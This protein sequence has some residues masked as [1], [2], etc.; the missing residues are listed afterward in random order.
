[1]NCLSCFWVRISVLLAGL[2]MFTAISSRAEAQALYY[3]G[4]LTNPQGEAVASQNPIFRVQIKS[5]DGTCLLYEETHN[6]IS[7]SIEGAFTIPLGKGDTTS[8]SFTTAFKNGS[9][10]ITCLSGG[11]YTPTN[12]YDTRQFVLSFTFDGTTW[13]SFTPETIAQTALAMDAATV[14]GLTANNLLRVDDSAAGSNLTPFTLSQLNSL[15][16]LING[17]S[18]QYVTVSSSLGAKMPSV[19]SQ[20]GSPTSGA[21]WFDTISNKLKYYDGT[22]VQ[23]FNTSTAT[24]TVTGNEITSGTIAGTTAIN[25]SGNIVTSGGVSSV[26]NSTNNLRIYDGATKYV[27]FTAPAGLAANY[28]LILPGALPVSNGQVLTSDTAGNLTWTTPTA[29]TLTS[30]GVTS[31]VLNSGTASAPIIAIQ[32]ANGTQGGYLSS[33]D[34]TTFNSKLSSTLADSSIWVGN[35]SGTATAV[36]PGGDVTMLNTG[37]F[38]VAKI[39]GKSVNATAPSSAG[40]VLRWD[41]TSQYVAA[42]LATGDISGLSTSLS[43]KIDSSQMPANCS[44]NQTLTFVSPTG[45][46]SCSNITV[47]GSAFGS[48]SANLVFAAPNGSAGNP[49]FRSL[50]AGDIPALD[51]NKITTGTFGVANGGTGISSLATNSLLYGNGTG[52]MSSLAPTNSGVL[53]STA[54]GVPQWSLLSAD[55]FTQYALLAGRAGGQSLAGGTAASENLTLD[56]T[57]HATKGKLV[58]APNGGEV[59][60]GTTSPQGKLEVVAGSDYNALTIGYNIASGSAN[61]GMIT[62][63]RKTQ[64]NAPFSGLGTWDDGINRSLFIGGGTWGRPDATLLKFHTATTYSETID[65]GQERMRIT[66]AGNVGIGTTNPGERLEISSGVANTS[67]LKFTNFT[68]TAPTGTGQPVG[69]DASGNLITVSVSG[70]GTVNSGTLNQMAFYN[71][72]GSAVSGNANVTANNGVLSLGQAGSVIGGLNLNGNTSGTVS[73]NPQAAAGTYNFNLPVDA[74]TSAQVLTSGG[75]AAA[76]MTWTTLATSATTDTTNASNIASGTLGVARLP[77]VTV[78]YGGTG[79]TSVA[80]NSLLYGK[81]AR[82]T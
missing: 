14:S 39:Q 1:M 50:V 41:G 2:V 56:S 68:S 79:L 45:S 69:V 12:A 60:I 37:A 46:W 19:A 81:T 40:Q 73:I 66:A 64:T 31:P 8:G 63:K 16:A 77:T 21:I 17:T 78:P 67:G 13:D 29:A 42:Q 38:T 62:G 82:V 58:L 25:T 30:V 48:Q 59:G 55:T 61:G 5:P 52:A 54:G 6:S 4:Q 70:S 53:T 15:T 44:A 23:T 43:S 7:T 28:G 27:Q 18:T 74:G 11:P 34:W 51:A 49:T 36:A 32:Q 75:G 35:G 9:S 26:T 47:T 22:T 80:T 76:P 72:T 10:S 3:H 20:P 24:G 71:A 65:Q 57:A 33:A